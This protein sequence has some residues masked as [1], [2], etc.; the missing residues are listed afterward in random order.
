MRTFSVRCSALPQ[1]FLCGGSAHRG[2]IMID[3]HNEAGALGTCAHEGL[4]GLVKTGRID[5]DGVP[6][7]ARKHNVQEDEG[8][9]RG[10]LSNG[11]KVWSEVRGRYPNAST[12]VY[13]EAEIE[14]GSDLIVKLTGTA[15]IVGSDGRVIFVGDWKTG[16]KDK[17]FAEQLKGYCAL[18]LILNPSAESA[19]AG[20]LWVREMQYEEHTM[21]RADL[22]P[23]LER[24]AKEVAEWNGI[25]HPGDEHCLYCMR[26]HECEAANAL[27]KRDFAIVAGA[28]LAGHLEDAATIRD[29]I[30]REPEKVAQ[31][32]AIARVAEKR[33]ERVIKAIRAEVLASGDIVGGGK[34]ITLQRTEK[35]HLKVLPAFE[36]LRE[37]GFGDAEF[38]EVLSVSASKAEAIVSAKAG[39]GNGAGAVRALREQL[40]QADAVRTF[41]VTSL[42][43]RRA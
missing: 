11:W 17:N 27:A 12:E 43:V 13:M 30:K 35:R 23:W 6:E 8:E 20:I 24:L 32:L 25:F 41:E 40:E 36:V 15:D 34:R 39:K 4:A 3:E 21:A 26:S 1:A 33:V 28:D 18:A 37:Q 19:T 16:R 7:L 38:S 5:W 10:L 2:E 22:E 42:V 29:M 31:L 9:L 14:V